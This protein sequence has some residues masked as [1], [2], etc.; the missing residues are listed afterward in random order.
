MR[1]EILD[2]TM[3]A[4]KLA[5]ALLGK[6]ICHQISKN[7]KRRFL[8]TETEAYFG[9]EE[10]CYGYKQNNSNKVFYSVGKWCAFADM[11]MIS[12]KNEKSPENILIRRGVNIDT[13]SEASGPCKL[14]DKDA[15][16][17]PNRYHN[18]VYVLESRG[19]TAESVGKI[20]IEDVGA[21]VDDK[22]IAK[23]RRVGIKPEKSDKKLNFTIKKITLSCFAETAKG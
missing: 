3:P 12:C 23:K 20:W 16:N 1:K 17:I 7:E 6:I 2:F 14:I 19:S 10:I 9:D 5:K 4:D 11:L 22:D 21:K 8:I 18:D 15:L 13:F